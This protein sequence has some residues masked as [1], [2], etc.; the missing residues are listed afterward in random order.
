ME[1]YDLVK[2]RFSV[3]KYKKMPV[4]KDKILKIM[5]TVR[6]APSAANYQPWHFIVATNE[7]LLEK[8]HQ[9]YARNWI[10]SAPVIIVACLDHGKS[11]KR[12]MD[13]KD[14]GDVDLAIAIDHL[15]LQASELGLGTC[16]ICNFNSEMC[17]LI[18]DLPV[19]IEALAL[20]PLGYPDIESPV[21]S[22][23][24]LNE[25]VHWEKF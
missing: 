22:R 14:F 25:I 6:M 21:K 11:W 15:T 18:L 24:A 19:N 5:E 9:T 3:R 10:K 4:E 8:L 12:G 20:L 16:W 1:F 13:G 17:S 2:A 23:K 7:N